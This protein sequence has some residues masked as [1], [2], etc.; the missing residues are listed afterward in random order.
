MKKSVRWI[1]LVFFILLCLGAGSLG[2]IA[3]TPEIAGWYQTLEKPSWNPPNSVF[4]PVWTTLFVMMAVAAWL[5]WK[6]KGFRSAAIQLTLFAI[7]LLLNVAWSWIF[8]G[9]HQPGWAFIEIIVLWATILATA[10]TFFGR[11]MMAGW[12]MMPYLAWVSFAAVLNFT[13]WQLNA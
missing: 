7:Q 11:S 8:F 10:V 1:G 4:G 3:T 5:V 12:L 2:A 13:I 9:M 6:P